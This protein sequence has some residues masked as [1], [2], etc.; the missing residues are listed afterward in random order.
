MTDVPL[1]HLIAGTAEAR[2]LSQRIARAGWRQHLCLEG[3][4]RLAQAWPV[5]TQQAR[6]SDRPCKDVS[7][8]I[9]ARHPFDQGGRLPVEDWA[10]RQN[11]PFLRLRRPTWRPGPKDRWVCLRSDRLVPRVPLRGLRLFCATGRDGL[12]V[13]RRL[14]DCYF[15]VRQLDRHAGPFPL[16][17]GRW[18][19]DTGPF[20]VAAEIA[21]MRRL[22]IDGIVVRNAGGQGAW[23][24][25]AAARQ[26]G[27]PVVLIDP[28][29]VPAQAR[30]V[31]EAMQWLKQILDV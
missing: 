7:C 9:D 16:P 18:V 15:L 21:V 30:S 28:P 19:F 8:V 13:L 1:I 25:L 29:P 12:M 14:K 23:P 3:A 27:L 17:R 11:V 26:L 22:R 24:K 10:R 31:D 20:S 6:P 2:V 5:A 4:S